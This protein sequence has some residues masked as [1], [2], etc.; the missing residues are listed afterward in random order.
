LSVSERPP[1]RFDLRRA[2]GRNTCSSARRDAQQHLSARAIERLTHRRSEAR[3]RTSAKREVPSS[4]SA[5][6]T[7]R[8]SRR[9]FSNSSA[10]LGVT[11]FEVGESIGSDHLPVVVELVRMSDAN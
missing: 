10:E 3:T 11:R 6:S 8:R 9:P 4:W 5:I 7:R 2:F 1:D